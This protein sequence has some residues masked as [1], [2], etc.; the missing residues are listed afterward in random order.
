MQFKRSMVLVGIFFLSLFALAGTADARTISNVTQGP[1]FSVTTT[2]TFDDDG[3]GTCRIAI[4]CRVRLTA[5][6]SNDGPYEYIWHDGSNPLN[7]SPG[8]SPHE[9]LVGIYKA[10]TH[11]PTVSVI[12]RTF[13]PDGMYPTLVNASPGEIRVPL[14]DFRISS[15]IRFTDKPFEV[16][17]DRS[18]VDVI[19]KMSSGVDTTTRKAYRTRC[20]GSGRRVC[21][22]ILAAPTGRMYIWAK[23]GPGSLP[24]LD[25]PFEFFRGVNYDYTLTEVIYRGPQ[26]GLLK[27]RYRASKAGRRCKVKAWVTGAAGTN[28][29]YQ[30][31]VNGKRS[32]YRRGTPSYDSPTKTLGKIVKTVPNGSRLVIAHKVKAKAGFN[33]RDGEKTYAPKPTRERVR[34]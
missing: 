25:E 11:R 22:R 4:A 2:A 24:K 18:P 20:P 16:V 21:W 8:S 30:S 13:R 10:G 27:A 32:R 29:R 6:A 9:V 5:R 12:D 34:C 26:V 33:G 7:T 31:V 19:W 15:R 17:A 1:G 14:L 28:Y 23:A 3:T